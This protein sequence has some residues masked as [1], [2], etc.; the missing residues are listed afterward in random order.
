MK[1]GTLATDEALIA[2]VPVMDGTAILRTSDA[3]YEFA[4]I[5]TPLKGLPDH[6]AVPLPTGGADVVLPAADVVLL[7]DIALVTVEDCVEL[8]VE[9]PCALVLGALLL[10]PTRDVV[11]VAAVV[12]TWASGRHWEYQEFCA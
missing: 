2:I 10:E 9:T 5:W 7:E 1:L 11:D 8:V 3:Y 12:G 6:V 4:H